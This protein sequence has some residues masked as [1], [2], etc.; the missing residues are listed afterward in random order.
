MSDIDIEW[1]KLFPKQELVQ[2]TKEEVQQEPNPEIEISFEDWTKQLLEEYKN[3]YELV[4]ESIPELWT[5]LEFAISIQKILNIKNCTLPF[6]GILLAAP[7]SLKSVIVQ[8]FRYSTNVYYTDS[9]SPKSFVSHY[10]GIKEKELQKIDMLPSIKNKFFLTSDLSPMFTK[11]EDELNE[12]IG[13]ITR[14][15]DGQGLVTN[16]G[17]CGQRGYNE[18]IMFTWL[19]AAV[20]IPYKVHRLMGSLGP[21]LYFFRLPKLQKKEEYLLKAMDKDD[22]LPKVKTIR[23]ALMKYLEMFERCPISEDETVIKENNLI[24]IQWDNEKDDDYTK[25]VIIRIALLLGHLRAVVPTRETYGTQ[26]MDYSYETAKIEEPE[27][28]ITQLRNLARG[29]ALSQGRTWITIQD[30]PVVIKTV[31]STASIDRVNIFDLLI[32][33][34]G[35][36]TTKIITTS[37]NKS[38]PTARRIMA[39]LKAVQL[40]DLEESETETQEKTITLKEDF[41]WFI[42]EQFK[43]RLP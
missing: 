33:H 20:D 24:K 21:K 12:I 19:G 25:R 9:F 2:E 26:G 38:P 42:S 5:P 35:T 40:V 14:V 29:H 22:F 8:L 16:T 27:R 32:A 17:S 39:E 6:A 37:L 11:N 28:A 13:L 41:E 30:L 18:E 15:L 1:N 43:K 3:L 34:K 31:L 23:L 10:A 7:S 4:N 36:L